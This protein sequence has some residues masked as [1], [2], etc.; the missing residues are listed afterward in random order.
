MFPASHNVSEHLQIPNYI[1]F[2]L[3]N[4]LNFTSAVSLCKKFAG[5]K[6]EER[7]KKLAF[8]DTL[9]TGSVAALSFRN[10]KASTTGRIYINGN[11]KELQ[12]WRE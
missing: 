6:R 4:S 8:D 11:I 7:R 3:P 1:L 12:Q 9:V 2:P 10:T 5:C